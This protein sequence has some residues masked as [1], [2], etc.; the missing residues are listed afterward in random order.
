[1]FFQS[2]VFSPSVFL[3]DTSLIFQGPDEVTLFVV[4]ETFFL[5]YS[6]RCAQS[7]CV[8]FPYDLSGQGTATVPSVF[9]T[10]F[11]STF[12]QRVYG[13]YWLQQVS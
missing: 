1:M 10:T 8:Y 6:T 9:P 7:L 5:F 13:K 4:V 2:E 12:T 3:Y 11:N